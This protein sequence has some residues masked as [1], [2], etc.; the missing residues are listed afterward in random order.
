MVLVIEIRNRNQNGE[1]GI[2]STKEWGQAEYNKNSVT[3][4]ASITQL[5]GASPHKLKSHRL[6]SQSVTCLGCGFSP[7]L[8]H[9]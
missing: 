1:L 9:M 6:Y 5:V 8:G 4:L 3:A 2:R 7:L